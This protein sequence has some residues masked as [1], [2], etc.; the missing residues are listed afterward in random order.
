MGI[1]GYLEQVALVSM[2]GW[3]LD[4]LIV[5]GELCVVVALIPVLL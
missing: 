1:Y 2:A 3:N 4:G 5:H